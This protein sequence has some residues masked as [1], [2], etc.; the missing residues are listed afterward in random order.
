MD[1]NNAALIMRY[2]YIPD[3]IVVRSDQAAD[4]IVYRPA[5]QIKRVIYNNPATVV[6]WT[7][8]TKTVVKC[9]SGDTFSEET[10]LMAAMLKRIYGNDNTYNKVMKPWIPCF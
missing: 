2:P 10:G 6:Y 5:P 8:G 4:L 9:Q 1:Q 3:R 7:D